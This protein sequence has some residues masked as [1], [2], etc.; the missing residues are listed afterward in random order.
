MCP[1]TRPGIGHVPLH[2]QAVSQPLYYQGSL[3]VCTSD[4]KKSLEMEKNP[5][6]ALYFESSHH[7]CTHI[8]TQVH[9]H[10]YT[11]YVHIQPLHTSLQMHTQHTGARMHSHVYTPHVHTQPQ[12]MCTHVHAPPHRHTFPAPFAGC[13]T[14]RAPAILMLGCLV[15]S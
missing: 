3:T 11:L 5:K 10:V 6:L 2:W 13:I 7:V 14:S 15:C 4:L 12:H 9:T 1:S 8:H